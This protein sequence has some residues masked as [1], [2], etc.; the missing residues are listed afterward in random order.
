MDL[1][2]DATCVFKLSESARAQASCQ[3]IV[4]SPP[5]CATS[6][7]KSQCRSKSLQ[8]E[9]STATAAAADA[10]DAAERCMHEALLR[11]R[12]DAAAEAAAARSAAATAAAEA[13]AALRHATAEADA[14]R[15][16]AAAA[17]GRAA[18]AAAEAAA[19]TERAAAADADA[20]DAG[21]EVARLLWE[22]EANT[23]RMQALEREFAQSTQ[24]AQAEARSAAAA[25]QATCAEAEAHAAAAQY[26]LWPLLRADAVII[27]ECM[28]KCLACKTI[29]RCRSDRDAATRRAVEAELRCEA[30]ATRAAAA[31][32]ARAAAEERGQSAVER[33]KGLEQELEAVSTRA[34]AA[35][36]SAAAA[37]EEATCEQQK[38]EQA[39]Q[40]AQEGMHAAGSQVETLRERLRAA[41]RPLW[42]S[43]FAVGRE[44][45]ALHARRLR[46]ECR[47]A[48]M[49]SLAAWLCLSFCTCKMLGCFSCLD[50]RQREC[51]A[52][53][54]VRLFSVLPSRRPKLEV[55]VSGHCGCDGR[56]AHTAAGHGLYGIVPRHRVSMGCM[57]EIG[58]ARERE[59]HA[60]ERFELEQQ[61]A[62]ERERVAEAEGALRQA[63]E[64]AEQAASAAGCRIA[65]LEAEVQRGQQLLGEA[66][67]EVNKET[68]GRWVEGACR[69][70]ASEADAAHVGDYGRGT[71]ASPD[72]VQRQVRAD[73]LALWHMRCG[74][75]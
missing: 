6:C 39:L 33:A 43:L 48:R 35:A 20:A 75:G 9:L 69:S 29:W 73:P 26:V 4:R 5:S 34:A 49:H 41:V 16:A 65:E 44:A 72:A 17:D 56:G 53:G 15:R 58:L 12:E 28:V 46:V 59:W 37:A 36:A 7:S 18:S 71:V 24:V 47:E 27:A 1:E 52:T 32:S 63:T 25:A 50:T 23:E 3:V 70:E 13:A 66:V 10:A 62:A 38:V 55:Q 60:A 11:Q 19:A 45:G 22:V 42:K 31:M 51:L 54:V 57:Q 30:E 67:S 68:A 74:S 8:N 61:V 2:C 40:A 14:L 64:V 21:R